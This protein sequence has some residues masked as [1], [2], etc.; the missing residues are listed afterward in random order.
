MPP[1]LNQ[2]LAHFSSQP[3]SPKATMVPA[4]LLTLKVLTMDL[5]AAAILLPAERNVYLSAMKDSPSIKA[6]Q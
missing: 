3:I 6:S 2:F 4:Q 5:G 1:Y